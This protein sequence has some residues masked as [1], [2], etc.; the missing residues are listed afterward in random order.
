MADSESISK[1]KWSKPSPT[2]IHSCNKLAVCTCSSFK[3]SQTHESAAFSIYP[4]R[5]PEPPGTWLNVAHEE[6]CFDVVDEAFLWTI[7]WMLSHSELVVEQPTRQPVV[8]HSDNMPKPSQL[9]LEEQVFS[10]SY[11]SFL[12]ELS[13]WY[14]LPPSDAKDALLTANVV[15]WASK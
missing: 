8:R 3:R 5:L 2:G 11:S 6:I 9:S 15:H 10:R 12:E 14:Y 7:N 1:C 13:V 4:C